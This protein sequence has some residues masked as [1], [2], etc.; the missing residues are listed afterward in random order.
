MR[1]WAAGTLDRPACTVKEIEAGLTIIC[2]DPTG[3]PMVIEKFADAEFP[4]ASVAVKVKLKVPFETGVPTI[5][6]DKSG[7]V[8]IL[9]PVGSDPP[10]KR[11]AGEGEN[12]LAQPPELVNSC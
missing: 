6:R 5:E 3:P 4:Q 1:I 12:G 2:A 7:L 8:S 9:R 10:D 11:K